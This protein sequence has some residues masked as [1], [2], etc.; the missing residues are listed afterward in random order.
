MSS[1]L[2]L[3]LRVCVVCEDEEDEEG[4][5]SVLRRDVRL[6][7]K[8]EILLDMAAR[9]GARGRGGGFDEGGGIVGEIGRCFEMELFGLS[10]L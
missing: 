5:L 4:G 3:C 9:S 7:R 1:A 10:L 8:S 2:T 6:E